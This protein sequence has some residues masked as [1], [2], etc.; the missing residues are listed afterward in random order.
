MS[1]VHV[2]KTRDGKYTILYQA[3]LWTR[4]QYVA[5]VVYTSDVKNV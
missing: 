3:I 1:A 4:Q 5:I 2:L